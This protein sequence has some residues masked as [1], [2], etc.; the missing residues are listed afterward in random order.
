MSNS[1]NAK[2][3]QNNKTQW[4]DD[5][6]QDKPP[7]VK[8]RVWE[9]INRMDISPEDELFVFVAILC[10][11]DVL[12]EEGP[13]QWNQLFTKFNKDLEEW[14]N[15]NLST[16]SHLARKKEVLEEMATSSKQLGH[17]LTNLT[18]ACS[19]LLV[20]LPSSN[21][22][23]HRSLKQLTVSLQDVQ[24]DLSSQQQ[25]LSSVTKA[26]VPVPPNSSH[27]N[28]LEKWMGP[29]NGNGI[30]KPFKLGMLTFFRGLVLVILV[31][32]LGLYL[33][34]RHIYQADKALLLQRTD[35]LLYKANKAEC[36]VFKTKAL[37]SDECS[38]F[39]K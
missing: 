11:L 6:L 25:Q 5:A 22:Q 35:W 2:T 24:R 18:Q 10:R 14:T 33:H 13:K 34:D 15:L 31:S 39:R 30:C 27:Q 32:N 28:T 7:E 17:I 9:L 19:E 38:A 4:L 26:I 37:S 20:T 21:Q 1:K 12:V 36:L 23:L 29:R 8:A 16:L 3:L